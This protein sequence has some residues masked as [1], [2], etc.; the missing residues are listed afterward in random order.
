MDCEFKRINVHG[1]AAYEDFAGYAR[2]AIAGP[3]AYVSGTTAV[4]P[5]GT[6]YGEGDA[7]AQ[8]KYIFDKLVG[9]LQKNGYT[10]E[11]VVKVN[12]WTTDVSKNNDITKAYAEYFKEFRPACSWIGVASLNRPTQL[13]EIEMQ[14]IKGAKIVTE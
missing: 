6:V 2:I 13:V 10:C 8:A 4:T 11:E 5:E 12:I 3:F 7:Y 9:L 14:A 1:G